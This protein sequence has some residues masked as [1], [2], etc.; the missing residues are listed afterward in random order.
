MRRSTDVDY[1]AVLGVDIGATRAQ[2]KAAYRLHVRTAHPDAGG[3]PE[4]FALIAQAWEV[5]GN[6]DER[7]YYDADRRLRSRQVVPGGADPD[8]G[9]TERQRWMRNKRRF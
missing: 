9:L 6:T 5:L 8:D 2:I 4:R 1:Y 3:D 7:E